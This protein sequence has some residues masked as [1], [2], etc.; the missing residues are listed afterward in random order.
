MQRALCSLALMTCFCAISGCG[1]TLGPT[2]KR[3][4]IVVKPGSP[5]LILE[6]RTVE[7]QRLDGQGPANVDIGGWVA[8]PQ[9]HFDALKRAA[10][11]VR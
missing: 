11:G 7:G 6:N 4:F 8:M 3:E 9:E 2:V 1:L 10:E 5:V